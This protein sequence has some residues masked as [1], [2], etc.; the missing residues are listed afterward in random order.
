MKTRS[1]DEYTMVFDVETTGL[2]LKNKDISLLNIEDETNDRAPPRCH[3][4]ELCSLYDFRTPEKYPIRYNRIRCLNQQPYITQLSFIVINRKHEIVHAFNEYINIPQDVEISSFI[5][6]LTGI[7]R[8]K[9]D[10]GILCENALREFV[11]WFLQCERIVAHNIEFDR[12]MIRIEMSRHQEVLS[13]EFPYINVVFNEHYDRITQL[14]HF[15]TM[16]RA[17]KICGIMVPKKSGEGTKLKPPKLIEMYKIFFQ[18]VPENLHNS[19]V[20]VLITMRCYLKVKYHRDIDDL[21][22]DDLINK[23]L[24][25]SDI[26]GPMPQFLSAS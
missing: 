16:I 4:R 14:D 18:H 20:D 1:S 2:F 23:S 22:F 15:D 5:T 17:N 24:K 13:S 10:S 9:C 26:R 21:Y 11:T 25:Q 8:E 6:N 7:T 3:D 12:T 19:I